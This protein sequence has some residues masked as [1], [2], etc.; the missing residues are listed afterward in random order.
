[1][2]GC[3]AARDFFAKQGDFSQKYFAYFKKKQRS[4][5]G[6]DSLSGRF[7]IFE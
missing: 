6:K 1:V 4:K 5:V 3:P 2:A 7:D